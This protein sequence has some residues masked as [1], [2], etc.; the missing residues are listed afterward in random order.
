MDPDPG[1]TSRV[2]VSCL[3]SPLQYDR[4]SY[5]VGQIGVGIGMRGIGQRYG[6]ALC[7][8]DINEI[9]CLSHVRPARE[10][11]FCIF[12]PEKRIPAGKA[13]LSVRCASARQ[14]V[15]CSVGSAG[16]C[17]VGGLPGKPI[18]NTTILACASSYCSCSCI[19]PFLLLL[20]YA[21]FKSYKMLNMHILCQSRS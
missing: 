4:R 2:S 6:N 21:A 7:P 18:V 5:A 19:Q 3:V 12:R 16:N 9:S 8:F 15:S 10:V 1:S 14:P 13:Y 11:T 20:L 17:V